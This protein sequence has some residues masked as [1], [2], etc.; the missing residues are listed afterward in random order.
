MVMKS[1]KFITIILFTLI[2]NINKLNASDKKIM[3]FD[4]EQHYGFNF[5]SLVQ[6]IYPDSINIIFALDSTINNYDALFM[7][8]AD[9]YNEHIID[10][11]ESELL[12]N[13]S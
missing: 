6:A 9:N 8:L 5:Y 13:S 11:T 1:I 3:I 12:L 7:F 4:P 10:S 2:I